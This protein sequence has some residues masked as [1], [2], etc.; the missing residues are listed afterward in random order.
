MQKPPVKSQFMWFQRN[1]SNPFF[2]PNQHIKVRTFVYQGRVRIFYAFRAKMGIFKQNKRKIGLRDG[3][4]LFRSPIFSFSGVKIAKIRGVLFGSLFFCKEQAK[5]TPHPDLNLLVYFWSVF[6]PV[7]TEKLY[8][9]GGFKPYKQVYNHDMPE[10][11]CLPDENLLRK[12][13][14]TWF[15]SYWGSIWPGICF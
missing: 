9:F 6:T 1:S 13:F 2:K 4:R 10:I 5:N 8:R 14:R 15:N 7:K 12:Y 11:S 3:K